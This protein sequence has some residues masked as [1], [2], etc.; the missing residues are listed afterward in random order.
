MS[1]KYLFL[2]AILSLVFVLAGSIPASAQTARQEGYVKDDDGNP[3]AGA[4]VV[5]SR[6]GRASGV[7][8]K[9]LETDQDGR[10]VLTG[11]GGGDWK[12]TVQ[13]SG[14]V[15]YEQVLQISS[16]TRNPH[17]EIILKKL[18]DIPPAE[19][20][21]RDEAENSVAEAEKLE[22]EGKYDEAIAVYDKFMVD[23]AGTENIFKM[24]LLIG[25]L[26]EKKRDY[27][28]AI[29]KYKLVVDQAPNDANALLY[30]GNAYIRNRQYDEAKVYYERLVELQGDNP[31]IL[32]TMAEMMLDN[33]NYEGAIEYYNKAIALN[34]NFGDAHM[35]L[36]YAYY[37]AKQWQN[38][39][40]AFE[41]FLQ[42]APNRPEAEFVRSDIQA[43][44]DKLAE[45]Q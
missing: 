3:I 8:L 29:E 7:N 30:L 23:H 33:S 21:V 18:E 12:I 20:S 44:K 13:A 32:Y 5:F 37:G 14:Y 31:N 26:Y 43:C 6:S 11:V 17:L 24:N 19:G 10:F 34:P 4:K 25:Q 36:G 16:F 35:K 1:K 28:A 41:K 27:A 42:I 39:I 45:Q 2:I 22:S 15:P 9:E 40:D 38:A